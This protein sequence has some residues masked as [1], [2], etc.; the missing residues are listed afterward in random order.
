M[1]LNCP[2]ILHIHRFPRVPHSTVKTGTGAV[3]SP[4]RREIHVRQKKYRGGSLIANHAL[5]AI[6][7]TT[8]KDSAPDEAGRQD[9]SGA[10]PPSFVAVRKNHIPTARK[11][12]LFLEVV[13]VN[14][15]NI[16]S[17]DFDSQLGFLQQLSKSV[18]V[19]K[20]YR[21]HAIRSGPP[22]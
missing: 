12:D 11:S 17:F 5:S 13:F 9:A 14:S 10:P 3:L 20:M 1:V 22:S 19:D 6:P 16:D 18:S 7:Q 4:R 8:S 21:I 2:G 15:D